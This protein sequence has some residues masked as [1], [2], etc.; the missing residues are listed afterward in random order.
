[1]LVSLISINMKLNTC[2]ITFFSIHISSQQH[3]YN[4]YGHISII[5]PITCAVMALLS[6][7]Q[8]VMVLALCIVYEIYLIW[9]KLHYLQHTEF[10]KAIK[11][12]LKLFVFV[13]ISIYCIIDSI[14]HWTILKVHTVL[15]DGD[16]LVLLL[17]TLTNNHNNRV[18][19]NV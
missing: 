1:M 5:W 18:S 16:N 12:V 9:Q 11:R 6:K 10:T 14:H 7:E 8:G 13:R 2:Y 15:I 4:T 3:G 19:T 17:R